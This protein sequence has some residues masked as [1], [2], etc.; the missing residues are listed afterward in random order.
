MNQQLK[1]QAA[2]NLRHRFRDRNAILGATAAAALSLVVTR[3]SQLVI[4]PCP[5]IAELAMVYCS[6]SLPMDFVRTLIRHTYLLKENQLPSGNVE[7]V[8]AGAFLAE[9]SKKTV[10]QCLCF[11]AEYPSIKQFG[12]G[13]DYSHFS[14]SFREYSAE[15][16]AATNRKLEAIITRK[17]KET[18]QKRA[19]INGGE[20]L[21]AYI[22]SL[23]SQGIDPRQGGIYTSGHAPTAR[24][25]IDRLCD[26]HTFDP[27]RTAAYAHRC[28]TTR[29]D[30]A[31]QAA[32]RRA[33]LPD[34]LL[35]E[36]ERF[37]RDAAF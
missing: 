25:T 32:A 21:E 12:K 29:E 14:A 18:D 15:W 16:T 36:E 27:V 10:W 13:F 20:Q 33:R 3:K 8:Q 7:T 2:D 31:R 28:C 11:V 26:G 30:F 22:R 23:I 6:D 4:E 17:Q 24:A 9:C 1:Q 5:T 37:R 19:A 34:W 35:T